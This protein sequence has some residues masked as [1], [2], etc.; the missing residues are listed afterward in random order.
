MRI[1]RR[2]A[3]TSGQKYIFYTL[4]S[5]SVCTEEVSLLLLVCVLIE[6]L[7]KRFRVFVSNHQSVNTTIDNNE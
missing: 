7:C 2:L 5:G 6:N 3:G 1:A 4:C